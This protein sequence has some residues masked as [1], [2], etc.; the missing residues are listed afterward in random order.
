LEI[1][2]KKGLYASLRGLHF[3]VY[4]FAL[5]LRRFTLRGLHF[6]VYASLFTAAP[7]NL[8]LQQLNYLSKQRSVNRLL[9]V[10]R[11]A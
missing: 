3:M 5:W 6:M 1:A 9:G 8:I 4:G 2:K 10:N 11:A 7:G